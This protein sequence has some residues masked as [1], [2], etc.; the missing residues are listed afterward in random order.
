MLCFENFKKNSAQPSE[1][2]NITAVGIN[3]N[4]NKIIFEGI[5]KFQNFEEELV[6]FDRNK[7]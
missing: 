4:A 5:A 1:T 2:I 6:L 7:S 3:I